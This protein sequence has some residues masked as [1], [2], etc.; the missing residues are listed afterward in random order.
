MSV[1]LLSLRIFVPVIR[2]MRHDVVRQ[3]MV[4]CL[5]AALCVHYI[6]HVTQLMQ[7]VIAF[8]LGGKSAIE[9]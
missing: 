2:Q 5:C 3:G 7:Q 8:D 4:P 6:P 1:F 9:E